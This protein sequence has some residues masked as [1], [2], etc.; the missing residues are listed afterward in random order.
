MLKKS[1]FDLIRE[2]H[3]RFADRE[4][5][6]HL[7]LYGHSIEE[8]EYNMFRQFVKHFKDLGYVG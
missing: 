5:P 7:A 6:S 8:R 1:I 3:I 2:F 4:L